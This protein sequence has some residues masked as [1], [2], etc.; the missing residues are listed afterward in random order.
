MDFSSEVEPQA[1]PPSTECNQPGA[2]ALLGV[3]KPSSHGTPVISV[4]QV[5]CWTRE[6]DVRAGVWAEAS[7]SVCVCPQSHGTVSH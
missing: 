7:S 4:Q 3:R 5:D 6:M 2:A 1:P